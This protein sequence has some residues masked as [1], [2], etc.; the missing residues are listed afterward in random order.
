MGEGN[1]YKQVKGQI[2]LLKVKLLEGNY[3]FAFY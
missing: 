1:D 3:E 2:Y